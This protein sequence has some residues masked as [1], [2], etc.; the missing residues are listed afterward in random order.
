MLSDFP[1]S[2]RARSQQD[3]ARNSTWPSPIHEAAVLL[4]QL[5]A[6]DQ[7]RYRVADRRAGPRRRGGHRRVDPARPGRDELRPRAVAGSGSMRPAGELAEEAF[8]AYFHDHGIDGTVLR[9]PAEMGEDAPP[10][11]APQ[12][13]VKIS[14]GR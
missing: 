8:P 13:L 5:A 12:R 10:Y 6:A 3:R 14:Q 11:A 7:A 9:Y 1:A 2:A 4:E